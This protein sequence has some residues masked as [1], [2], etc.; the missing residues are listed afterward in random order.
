MKNKHFNFTI[1]ELLTVIAIIAILAGLLLP[2]LQRAR[3]SAKTAACLSNQQQVNTAIKQAMNDSDQF[4]RSLKKT[5]S[6]N[7]I[8][9]YYWSE[10]LGNVD[11]KVGKKYLGDYKIMRCPGMVINASP[12]EEPTQVYGVVYTS[13]NNEG[14]DFRGTKYLQD[15]NGDSISPSALALG[16]CNV[17]SKTDKTAQG[18]MDQGSPY[19]IHGNFTNMFF[20]DGHAASIS[21]NYA[22]ATKPTLEANTNKAAYV[23]APLSDA[24]ESALLTKAFIQE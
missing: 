1:I 12:T 21:E 22:K 6:G 10:Y 9:G 24:E 4:F 3:K 20:L 5:G 17:T 7:N 18:L 2:A 14:L 23:A 16:V 19:Q 11:T 13:A 8:Q 15:A